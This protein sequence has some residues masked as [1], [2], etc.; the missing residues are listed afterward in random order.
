MGGG[1]SHYSSEDLGRIERLAK[2]EIQKASD[3]VKR[4][5]FIY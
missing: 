5:V 1:G 2:Q 3:E 4:N